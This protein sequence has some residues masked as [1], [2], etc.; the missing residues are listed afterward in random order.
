[1]LPTFA[2]TPAAATLQRTVQTI[3]GFALDATVE[4]RRVVLGGAKAVAVD[5]RPEMGTWSTATLEV[6]KAQAGSAKLVAFS[7]PKTIAA[8][9]GRVEM[10]ETELA[11]VDEIE[12]VHSG[13]A[14]P[15]GS[16]AILRVTAEASVQPFLRASPA[17]TVDDVL[18]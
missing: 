7:T 1:M 9:G 6:R 12:I 15:S 10:S 13:A 8:G 14:G 16:T 4:R 5:A 2:T 18:P 17:T 3:T 11:G